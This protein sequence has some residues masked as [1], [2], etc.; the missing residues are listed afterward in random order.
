MPIFTWMI[1]LIFEKF[2]KDHW[3]SRIDVNCHIVKWMLSPT[4]KYF[5]QISITKIFL[6]QEKSELNIGCFELI[7]VYSCLHAGITE[8]ENAKFFVIAFTH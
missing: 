7:L 3:I 4:K 1:S 5:I 6:L 8:S 2:H